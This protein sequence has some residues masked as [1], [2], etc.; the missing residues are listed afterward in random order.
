MQQPFFSLTISKSGFAESR[1]KGLSQRGEDSG[2]RSQFQW[3]T[4]CWI[5]ECRD[6]KENQPLSEFCARNFSKE[7]QLRGSE[8]K[9][10]LSSS[11][12][13]KQ[14]PITAHQLTLIF[15]M[16][17]CWCLLAPIQ[18]LISQMIFIRKLIIKKS[19]HDSLPF[20]SIIFTSPCPQMSRIPPTTYFWANLKK[21]ENRNKF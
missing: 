7:S 14:F 9:S 12:P 6:L 16:I 1:K 11:F 13:S 5:A 20:P 19:R 21:Q 2:S 10:S 18:I 8:S 17:H 3:G 4:N 15:S